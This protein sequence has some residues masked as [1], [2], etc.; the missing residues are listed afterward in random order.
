[1]LR[2]EGLGVDMGR[3]VG[4]KPVIQLLQMFGKGSGPIEMHKL[5]S[6]KTVFASYSLPCHVNCI[7]LLHHNTSYNKSS[8]YLPPLVS[9]RN[10]DQNRKLI[11]WTFSRLGH[12]INN[13]LFTNSC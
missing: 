2:E 3:T 5:L 8:T 12:T 7:H 13:H 9:T 4:R 6:C 11:Q 10:L 1:M